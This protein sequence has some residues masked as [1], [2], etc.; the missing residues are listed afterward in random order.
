MMRIVF[1]RT[2]G[3]MGRKVSLSIDLAD[4]P[5]DQAGTLK[6]LVDESNF[7]K[8]TELPPKTPLPDGFMYSITV[9]TETTQRTIHASDTNFPQTLR[10]LLENLL[11]RARVR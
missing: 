4:L 7:F 5:P 3:F 10:P 1:E 9:E 8:L 2:G 6:Q 11:A